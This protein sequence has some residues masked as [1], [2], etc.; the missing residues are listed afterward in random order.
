[1]F[2]A[3]GDDASVRGIDMDTGVLLWDLGR[4]EES[5]EVSRRALD[6]ALL[7]ED[8]WGTFGL[9]TRLAAAL[10][11]LDRAEEAAEVM[12]ACP[13][14]PAGIGVAERALNLA[15]RARLSNAAGDPVAGAPLV[16][17]GL[18][19]VDGTTLTQVQAVLHAAR[20]E[21]T[22]DSDPA[23]AATERARATALFLAAGEPGRAA[24]VSRPFLPT[25]PD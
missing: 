17:E 24:E 9:A 18:E 12:T 6:A 5:V 8:A 3:A 1:V 16:D 15:A 14:P 4:H 25:P 19:L 20:A 23:A 11:D 2:D 13:D 22:Q 21:I 10:L 7:A